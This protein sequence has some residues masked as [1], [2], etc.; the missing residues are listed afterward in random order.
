MASKNFE[1]EI[2][3]LP[4]LSE[5][6]DQGLI[7]AAGFRWL[8]L[9]SGLVFVPALIASQHS[10]GDFLRDAPFALVAAILFLAASIVVVIASAQHLSKLQHL[11]LQRYVERLNAEPT[12]KLLEAFSKRYRYTETEVAAIVGIL[13]RRQPGWRD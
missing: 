8:G 9:L 11:H 5:Y 6:Q 13:D 12:H 2:Y 1:E 7:R 3:S 10:D 4:R